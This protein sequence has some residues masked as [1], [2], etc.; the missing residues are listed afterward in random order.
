MGHPVDFLKG[1]ACK[2][3]LNP[4]PLETKN[5]T[6]IYTRYFCGTFI[7]NTLPGAFFNN[8][9]ALLQMQEIAILLP[10]AFS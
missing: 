3:L 2:S 8:Y 5:M 1:F 10:G 7:L 6:N 4:D 9:S